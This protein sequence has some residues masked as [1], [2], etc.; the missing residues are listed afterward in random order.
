MRDYFCGWYFKCQSGEQTLALIP[1][2]HRTDG[3]RFNS[4][5]IITESISR[6]IFFPYDA[7]KREP[8]GFSIADC[9]FGHDGIILHVNEEGISVCGKI[10]FGPFSRIRY[11]IMGP[12]RYMPFMECRHS[13]KSMSHTLS[14]EVTLNGQSYKLGGGKGYIEGDRGR[15]FPSRYLWTHTFFDGGSLM[16]SIA[17]IPLG[18]LNFTGI[19]G[20]IHYRGREY[21]IATY[22]GARAAH[23]TDGEALVRQGAYELSA[24]LIERHPLP[25]AAP[26]SGDMSRTIHE[27]ASCIAEYAFSI[28]KKNLFSFKTDR[29]S[30]ESEM[31]NIEPF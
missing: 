19:I 4:M 24:R 11:D 10:V 22:L 31:S 12:F 28:N 8:N 25:L 1:A 27:S 17:D 30:F 16:L 21:R 3:R 5:Q 13:I 7:L 6:T 9:Y 20:L 18:V 23:L 15:S 26:R 14:G 2:S 29:A